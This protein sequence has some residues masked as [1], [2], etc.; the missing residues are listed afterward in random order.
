MNYFKKLL[1]VLSF[2]SILSTGMANVEDWQLYTEKDGIRIEY[3]YTDCDFNMGYDQQWVLLKITN[4][5][6]DALL[7]EWKNNLWYN[8]ECK[9]C[10]VKSQEYHR[11]VSID[12]GKTLEGTC[13][14]YSNGDLTM[15]VKFIDKRYQNSN[16]QKLTKFK[17]ASLSIT[18]IN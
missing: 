14:L 5:S 9:T 4:T 1:S 15:F 11:S 17:L 18:S 13:S 12:S 3:K 7:V 6:S 2:A 16:P 8:N 10:D